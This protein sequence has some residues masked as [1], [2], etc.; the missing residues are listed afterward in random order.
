MSLIKCAECNQEVSTEAI[1]C[2]HCGKPIPGQ[3]V[4]NQIDEPES[5]RTTGTY[6]PMFVVV[7]FVGICIFILTKQPFSISNIGAFS[8]I[9]SSKGSNPSTSTK[10]NGQQIPL[11]EVKNLGYDFF[12]GQIDSFG[13][14]NLTDD[15]KNQIIKIAYDAH[16]PV[17]LLK[18]IPIIVLNNL[19]L[20]GDQYISTANGNFKVPDLKPD[21]LSE[22]G[23]Y[24]TFDNGSAFIFINK[25]IIAQGQLTDVLTHELG[26]A[27]GS[28]LTD[29]EWAEF[30]QL[31]NIP[32]STPRHG[33]N[34]NLSP[35]EDFAEVYKNTYTGIAIKT[36][37][38]SLTTPSENGY[39][40]V[41]A[42]MEE[43]RN[44]ILSVSSSSYMPSSEHLMYSV[45]DITKNFI[46]GITKK[47]G[48]NY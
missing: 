37:Y 7:V 45:D 4:D 22:G 31:R 20:S 29:Q 39:A 16:F 12:V 30:Y 44:Q 13:T 24:T 35:R 19:A 46:V 48:L 17:S 28:K 34:W 33:T 9:F 14:N 23:I 38:G 6:F 41:L 47:M 27:I 1:A 11:Q 21:W 8:Q 26:H 18:N 42:E 32:S 25:P 15:L 10:T 2:P 40:K 43:K 5:L 36:Y 3:L